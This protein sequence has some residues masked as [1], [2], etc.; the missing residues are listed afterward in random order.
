MRMFPFHI[1]LIPLGRVWLQL[2]SL[3]LW[4]NS[5]AV[6]LGE[7]Q[8]WIWTCKIS[9]SKT[10]QVSY[11]AH[12]EELVY[13]YI[14]IYIYIYLSSPTVVECDPK[15]AFSIASTPR[16]RGGYYSFSWIAPLTLDS[17]HIML[18]VKQGG[19]KYHFLSPW[20]NST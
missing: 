12:V 1:A 20:Y 2:F 6:S 11:S 5:M 4:V 13:I 17:Y 19:I 16:C 15:A 3:K 7:G 14:Y 18:S 9:A 10:D 8:I